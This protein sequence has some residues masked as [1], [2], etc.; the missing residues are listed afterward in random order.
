MNR[1]VLL[2][3][4]ACHVPVVSTSQQ[5]DTSGPL[6]VLHV[7]SDADGTGV[8]G[9]LTELDG[10]LYGLAGER[11]PNGS[12]SCSSTALWRT[13]EHTAHC[14]GSLFSLNRDGSGFRVDH[15]F[16]QLNE[17]GQSYDGYHPYGTLAV[18]PDHRLY[19]VTQMGGIPSGALPETPSGFGVLF[20]YEPPS[21]DSPG[22]FEILHHFFSEPRAADGE[23]PMGAL[24][25]DHSGN[26]FGT[27]KGGGSGGTGTVWEWSP[28]GAFCYAPLPGE[29]YGGVTLAGGLLHGTTWS[30]GAGVY[31]TVDPATLAVRVVDNFRAISPLEHANDNTPIQ[32]PLVLSDGSVIA[33][34]EFGGPYGTGL[35]ARLG[36]NGITPLWSPADLGPVDIAPRFANATGAMLNGQIVEGRDGM[37]YGT[38]TY[39][40]AYGT[41]GIWRMARDGSLF[42][43]LW[44]WPDAAYPYGGLSIGSD[45]ALYGVTFNTSQ[46]FRFVPPSGACAP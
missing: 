18:G 42:Q 2:A 30:P 28:G 3:L 44:S 15:A 41:G 26:V 45:G 27:A 23:H 37:I 29:S 38:A 35:I 11:G 10:R 13:V 36:P 33:V 1:F 34:R 16:T 20:A 19:G 5:A 9:A 14:P 25:I 12:P 4:A 43:L 46:V 7:L 31:F 39:G 21:A 24:A 8:R 22:S 17:L 6:T 32:S 40:G